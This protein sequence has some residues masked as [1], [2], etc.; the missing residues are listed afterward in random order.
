MRQLEDRIV[1]VKERSSYVERL[2]IEN[3]KNQNKND[4]FIDRIEDLVNGAEKNKK[5]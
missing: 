4:L 2:E 3:S 5:M 1:V